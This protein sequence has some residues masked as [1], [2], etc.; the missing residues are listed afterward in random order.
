MGLARGGMG[1]LGVTLLMAGCASSYYPWNGAKGYQDQPL[2]DQTYAVSYH[3]EKGTDWA[4]LDGYLR[5]RCETLLG[6][7]AVSV[8]DITHRI[9]GNV[10]Q[11]DMATSAPV[12]TG[13]DAMGG[14]F[15][16]PGLSQHG[17]LFK[18]RVAEGVCSP[19]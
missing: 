6:Q 16:S 7:Q 3:A 14:N 2:G 13:G 8:T 1:W 12:R 19:D 10:A 18:L 15:S 9:H 4:V 17:V 11:S 5:R